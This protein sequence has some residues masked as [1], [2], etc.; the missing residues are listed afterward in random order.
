MGNRETSGNH[1][2]PIATELQF[3]LKSVESLAPEECVGQWQLGLQLLTEMNFQQIRADRVDPRV[4][5]WGNL[6]L[7]GALLGI[8]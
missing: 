7:N 4:T 2:K 8:L 1:G 6:V 3:F 5:G